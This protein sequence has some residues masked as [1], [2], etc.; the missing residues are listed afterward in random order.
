MKASV[1]IATTLDGFIARDNGELDWLPGGDGAADLSG[2][3][4]GYAAFMETVDVIVMGRKTYEMVLS[5]GQ[6]PYGATRVVVLSNTLPQVDPSLPDT[7]KTS[8]LGVVELYRQ[9]A[10][11]G[12]QH[13]YVDGGKTIQGFLGA[14]L[15]DEITVTSIPVL[16]GSGIPLFGPLERDI[17][18]R[19]ISTQ[20]YA[21]GMVQS[22][23][24]V[25]PVSV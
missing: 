18:L 16:I 5:F 15:I 9:L 6:W 25:E 23:Y 7:V 11:S 14:G 12:V 24:G 13:I 4:Y 20:S 10:A 3:D 22:C 21:N 1:Y 8:D 2:E 17:R 19:H